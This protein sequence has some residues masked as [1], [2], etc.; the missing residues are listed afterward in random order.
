[1][2]YDFDLRMT[3]DLDIGSK[4]VI[5]YKSLLL[6]QI[7]CDDNMSWSCYLTLVSASGV[8]SVKGSKVIKGSFPVKSPKIFKKS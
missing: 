8:C 5:F 1:M 2:P 4:N 7:T 3:F 6:R